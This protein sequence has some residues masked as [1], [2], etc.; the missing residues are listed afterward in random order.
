MNIIMIRRDSI[1]MIALKSDTCKRA[2][3]FCFL[4]ELGMKELKGMKEHKYLINLLKNQ[5]FMLLHSF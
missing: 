2:S 3:L 4:F 1:L 5:V